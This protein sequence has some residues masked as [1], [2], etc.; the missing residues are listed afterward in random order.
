[1]A[2]LLLL[3][4]GASLTDGSREP[5]ML[6]VRGAAST[7]MI[8]CGT[9]PIRQLQRLGVP[10]ASIDRLILTHGEPHPGNSST[11][12]LGW[13]WWTGTPP[14][15]SLRSVTSGCSPPAREVR[16]RPVDYTARSGRP[17]TPDLRAR[18][19]LA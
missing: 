5:T 4:T 6:A 1:M 19:T 17:L 3:G 15:G 16:P 2:E 7:V 13:C 10:L 12:H 18:C 14:F 8:D 11:H 9:N